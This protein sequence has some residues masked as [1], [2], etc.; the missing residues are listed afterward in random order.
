MYTRHMSHYDTRA[1]S[2]PRKITSSQAVWQQQIFAVLR[3]IPN[4]VH[5]TPHRLDLVT[6]P[7]AEG[8]ANFLCSTFEKRKSLPNSNTYRP[9]FANPNHLCHLLAQCFSVHNVCTNPRLP[10]PPENLLISSMNLV[11]K[12]FSVIKKIMESLIYIQICH[13]GTYYDFCYVSSTA[14]RL[15]L[16]IHKFNSFPDNFGRVVPVVLGVAEAISKVWHQ[17]FLDGLPFV[18]HFVLRLM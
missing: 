11:I 10:L 3:R 5:T 18:N 8:Q 13:P 1:I 4:P 15:S 17:A 16:L 2:M 6:L 14:D 12:P 9:H 7:F